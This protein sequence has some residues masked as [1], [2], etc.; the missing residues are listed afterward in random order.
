M[1]KGDDVILFVGHWGEY[2]KVDKLLSL[3][4]LLDD[5]SE[6]KGIDEM[7]TLLTKLFSFDQ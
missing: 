4:R 5:F 6:E 7:M 1:S 3:L 2:T